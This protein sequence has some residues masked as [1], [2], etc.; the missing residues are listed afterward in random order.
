LTPLIIN[1]F[2]VYIKI[3]AKVN[4]F[5]FYQFSLDSG[6]FLQKSA[7]LAMFLRQNIRRKP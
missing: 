3:I 6:A 5:N 2:I 7:S 1:P 4:F